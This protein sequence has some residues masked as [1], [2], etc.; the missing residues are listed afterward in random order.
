MDTKTVYQTDHL[1]IL[2]GET[3]ADR[4]PLEPDVW[5]VPGGCVEVIPPVVP[6]KMAAHWDGRRWQLIDSYQ[7][8]TAYS[9][10]TGEPSVIQRAG[11]IPPGY[12]L[13][14]PRPG[15]IWGNG[16][17]VDDIPAEV[18]RRYI[19]LFSMINQV[20]QQEITG[21]FWSAALGF[22]FYYDTELEDQLN[23][24]G[25]VLRGV[26]S[27]YACRNESGV[28]EFLEHSIDQLRQVSDEF[29]E[30]KLLRLRKA[31]DLKLRLDAARAA[32]DLNA[33]NA[34]VWEATP[35]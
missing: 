15:Q 11:A 17:W 22:H 5:L 14:A 8:L 18:E 29:T 21:G 20:C 6:E 24:T 30:F 9:T 2:I 13:E 26:D 27:V 23:L 28:K 33:I 19:V 25:M 32:Q 3:V 34:V 4:S 1:G 16:H 12:T 10:V 7:G 31:N 35:V